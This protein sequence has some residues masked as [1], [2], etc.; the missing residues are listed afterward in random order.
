MITYP[1]TC[2][3][4]PGGMDGSGAA[5]CGYLNERAATGARGGGTKAAKAAAKKSAKVKAAAKKAANGKGEAGQSARNKSKRATL[6]EAA[7]EQ[8]RIAKG[9]KAV[10]AVNVAARKA[11]NTKGVAT[12]KGG[13]G[14]VRG[15][16]AGMLMTAG[17]VIATDHADAAA[18]AKAAAEED[19][20]V[21]EKAAVIAGA[22][23]IAAKANATASFMVARQCEV[24]ARQR[25]EYDV[26]TK[27][28]YIEERAPCKHGCGA[29]VWPGEANLWCKSGMYI[30]NADCNPPLRSKTRH[31]NAF[32]HVRSSVDFL[33]ASANYSLIK[34]CTHFS[35]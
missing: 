12:K 34:Q 23:Y 18:I 6:E 26:L 29:E 31:E 15:A 20:K 27:V 17:S 35:L 30:L 28:H 24:E 10:K 33:V 4:V 14:V 9:V 5:T 11:A 16:L 32:K 8:L 13:K 25:A 21:Q 22:I 1:R 7:I 19:F 3:L 2:L